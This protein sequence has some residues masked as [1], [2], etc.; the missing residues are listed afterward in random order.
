MGLKV[1]TQDTDLYIV[2][3]GHTL[4]NM[5]KIKSLGK[6]VMCTL[7]PISVWAQGLGYTE[8]GAS[9]PNKNLFKDYVRKMLRKS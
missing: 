1:T 2:S 7:A 4:K 3:K 5:L 9:W 8:L 6:A